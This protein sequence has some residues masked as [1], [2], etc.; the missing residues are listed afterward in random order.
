MGMKKR[1]VLF[2]GAALVLGCLF[3]RT[4]Q[5]KF[6]D[7][8]VE[9]GTQSLAAA[10]FA[11]G[12]TGHK[13]VRFVTDPSSIDLGK[14][15]QHTLVLEWGSR[16]E[17]VTLTVADTTA[18]TATIPSTRK[19]SADTIPE[20]ESLVRDIQDFS[21]VKVYYKQ[22]PVVPLD[23]RDITVTVVVE[24]SHGNTLEKDCTFSFLWIREDLTLELGE[25]LTAQTLLYNP[26]RD[27]FLLDQM[28]LNRIKA[29]GLGEYTVETVLDGRVQSCRILVRDTQGPEL[30][31]KQVQRRY[32]KKLQARDFVDSVTDVSGIRELRLLSEVD[33]KEKGH[34]PVIIEAEDNCG[35]VTRGETVLWIASDYKLPVI[36]GTMS[37]ITVEKG[38]P[39]PDLLEGITATDNK[40]GTIPVEC[41]TSALDLNKGGTYYITYRATDS[42]GNVSTK[43]RKVTVIHD[44]ADTQALVLSI[45]DKLGNDPATIRK[46][47]MNSI[48]YNH[49][50]GGEDPLW[51]G[52][53]NR[54]GNCY[55]HALCMKAILDIKGIENQLIWVTD[56][57]HYWLLVKVD[58][59]WTHMDPTPTRTPL[60]DTMNDWK[61]L[62]T[63]SGRKWD[64]TRW[65]ACG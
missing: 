41:D 17:T 48:G 10:D 38:H 51:Q 21:E 22:E 11:E 47:V 64:T 3:L 32:N 2:T 57:S 27:S 44:E 39:L 30:K 26:D 61:R 59:N 45:A 43:K 18:P 49:D 35:N 53:V 29:G 25:E 58:G 40:D 54:R 20:A 9:L 16:Q 65:P 34:Y 42:S 12:N 8:T 50:W 56:E 19:V 6:H 13:P 60:P 5:P 7:L 1:I 28:E 31:L 62:A 52:F 36:R 37:D 14:P 46:Y 55:V 24:D 23:Y 33:I 4:P 63:L 15:G